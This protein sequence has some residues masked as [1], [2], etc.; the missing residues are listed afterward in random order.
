VSARRQLP[1]LR[2][3][4]SDSIQFH[5]RPEGRRTGRLTERLRRE[6]V[7]RNPPIVA[8]IEAERCMLLDGANRVTAC[9]DIG[10]SHIPVQWVEYGSPDIQLKGWHHLLLEGTGLD[11]RSACAAIPGVRLSEVRSEQLLLLLAARHV[12]AVLVDAGGTFWGLFPATGHCTLHEW[13]A[14][15]HQVVDAYEGRSKVERIKWAD[16]A[17][18]LP[19]YESLEHQIVL[20]PTLQKAELLELAASGTLIPTGISRHLVPGRALGLNLELEFLSRLGSEHALQEHFEAFVRRLE[21]EGRIRF[22][23]EPVFILNE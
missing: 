21:V 3:V 8:G 2:L 13:I 5:E 11:L 14:V 7:L 12:Y 17:E 1:D 19:S 4:R 15:L 9:R 20:F 6:Q 10:Y 18:L 22:Y 23:E 16:D